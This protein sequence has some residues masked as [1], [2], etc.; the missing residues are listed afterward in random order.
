MKKIAIIVT[1]LLTAIIA[2]GQNVEEFLPDNDP[3]DQIEY[4]SSIYATSPNSG[5]TELK[6][7][8]ILDG[9]FVIGQEPIERIETT[10]EAFTTREGSGYYWAPINFRVTLSDIRGAIKK[11]TD[12]LGGNTRGAKFNF[13]MTHISTSSATPQMPLLRPLLI[14]TR[15]FSD[16]LTNKLTGKPF[17]SSFV[18]FSGGE[19]QLDPLNPKKSTILVRYSITFNRTLLK[20]VFE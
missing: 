2:S 7:V 18:L 4:S 5:I 9:N 16:K 13:Q 15:A 1:T 17:H 14:E 11:I 12:R 10:S 19:R 3:D 8:L 6:M 20:G